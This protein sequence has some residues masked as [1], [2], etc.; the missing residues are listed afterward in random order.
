MRSE[1]HSARHRLYESLSPALAVGSGKSGTHRR[2]LREPES[3]G[4]I[5]RWGVSSFDVS[6]MEELFSVPRGQNC[7]TNQVSYSLQDRGI[8]QDLLP[9]SDQHHMPVMAFSPLGK[10]AF[11]AIRRPAVSP[12]DTTSVRL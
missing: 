7:T 8:E 12:C 10:V 6:D 5:C 4:R 11:C 9:W 1:S 3:R 2:Y